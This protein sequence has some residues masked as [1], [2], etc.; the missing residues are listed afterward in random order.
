MVAPAPTPGSEP[1]L[2]LDA[3]RRRAREIASEGRG[4]PGVLNLVP[5]PPPEAKKFDLGEAIAKAAKPDCRNAYADLG[6]LALPPLIAS[7]VGNGGC[8]W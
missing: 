5:P 2:D 4:S 1:R 6:F 3:T 7:T 8:N